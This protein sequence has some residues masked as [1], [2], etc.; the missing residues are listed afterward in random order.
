MAAF[1][2]IFVAIDFSSPSDEALRQAHARAVSS[3]AKLAVCHIVPNELRSN[4]LFPHLSR[5]DAL[6]VPIDVERAA[7]AVLKHVAQVTGQSETD[8]QIIADHGTP[9]AEILKRAE[10][11]GADLIIVGSHGLTSA[12]GVFLGSV[13]DKVIRYAH[14]AVL[15]ARRQKGSR[16]IVAGTDFSDP[17][18]PAIAAASEE[19]RRTHADL[20]VV[21]CLD[22]TIAAAAP[23][24]VGFGM[25]VSFLAPE[26]YAEMQK[27]ARAKLAEA[28]SKFNVKAELRVIS[29]PAGMS[30]VS[31]SEEEAAD[32]LVVGTVGRTGLSRVLL[33]SVAETAAS[34]SPCSV[35]VVRLQHPDFPSRPV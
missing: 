22:L 28:V 6:E 24:T 32:L 16:R 4:L 5:R 29:G 2:N 11:W 9:H 35:L 20:I 7:E 19:A 17:A 14:C 23:L 15:V 33:G 13:T 21:H 12:A 34:R 27:L 25:P 10:D 3:G 1:R 30:L 31:V 26:D 18:L 8:F